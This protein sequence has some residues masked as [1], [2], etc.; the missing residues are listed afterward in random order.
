MEDDAKALQDQIEQAREEAIVDTLDGLILAAHQND[1]DH[2]TIDE[3]EF[4]RNII[5][6]TEDAG[7]SQRVTDSQVQALLNELYKS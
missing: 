4:T 3:L 7:L 1:K 6:D 2:V 5:T